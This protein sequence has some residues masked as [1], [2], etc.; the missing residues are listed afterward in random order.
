MPTLSYA[1]SLLL[2]Y[3]SLMSYLTLTV[4]SS[5]STLST[6]T[7]L[8]ALYASDSGTTKHSYEDLQVF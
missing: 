7:H 6:I 2:S 8:H 4:L 3:R 1:T 5:L